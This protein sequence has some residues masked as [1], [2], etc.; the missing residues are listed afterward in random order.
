MDQPLPS[1]LPSSSTP[2]DP[3]N[4]ATSPAHAAGQTTVTRPDP[5]GTVAPPPSALATAGAAY[6]QATQKLTAFLMFVWLLLTF[7][8]AYFARELAT[9][10][11]FGWPLSFYM[12]AQ[13][14]LILFIII[15]YVYA[16]RMQRLDERYHAAVTTPTS[17][18]SLKP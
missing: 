9:I 11:F 1:S 10:N 3:V 8:M 16:R 2:S 14:S 13:G 5:F 7:V 6:W 17:Q 12:S 18:A 15:I 4:A